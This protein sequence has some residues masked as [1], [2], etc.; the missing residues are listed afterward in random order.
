MTEED[1]DAGGT[2]SSTSRTTFSTPS[3]IPPPPPPDHTGLYYPTQTPTSGATNVPGG[4]PGFTMTDAQ[5]RLWMSTQPR[6][7]NAIAVTKPRVGGTNLF[8]VWTGYGK[9]GTGQSER[10]SNC[11]REFFQRSTKE[12]SLLG[13]IADSCT[14][15]LATEPRPLALTFETQTSSLML[16]L[17]RLKEFMENHGMEATFIIETAE[18]SINM[19]T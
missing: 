12:Y 14:A 11:M 17:R 5:F 19:F 18:E 10:T 15:G 9:N 8:G 3:N 13:K 7:T 6:P 1:T 4:P 16:T 2:P